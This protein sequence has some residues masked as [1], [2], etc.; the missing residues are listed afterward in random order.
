MQEYLKQIYRCYKETPGI[1]HLDLASA[2]EKTLI[3]AELKKGALAYIIKIPVI[4]P[5]DFTYYLSDIFFAQAEASASYLTDT[6]Y[7]NE[8][9]FVYVMHQFFYLCQF[10]A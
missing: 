10:P 3:L 7:N 2:Y 1:L 6:A 4:A 8:G 5:V 9:F